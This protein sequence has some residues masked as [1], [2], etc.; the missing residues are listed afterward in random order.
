VIG[1]L[2]ACLAGSAAFL[3]LERRSRAPMLPLEMFRTGAFS[4][5]AA[6]GVLLNVGFYGLLFI[7]PL[8]FERVHHYTALRTGLALLPAM[9][10]VAA[11]SAVSG[12]VAAHTG[13]RLPIVTGLVV[14]AAGLLGWLLAGPRVP[15]VVVAVPMA[16]AAAGTAFTMP[17]STAAIMEA[18]PAERA[19]AAS[20]VFN[21]ARQAGTAVGVAM[22]GTL[23][24]GGLVGGLHAGVATGGAA[25]VA[26]AVLAAVY[27]R[28]GRG[29]RPAR[30][31]ESRSA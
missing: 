8:Y 19:G 9:G 14:G 3:V 18:A 21:A 28:P 27:I 20:A 6:V 1:A 16:A 15:Y 4:A 11:S 30:P 10:L 29:S 24:A 2:A 26:A 17:A 23:A 25:F 22:F 12:R 5:S 31:R 13:P 7:A